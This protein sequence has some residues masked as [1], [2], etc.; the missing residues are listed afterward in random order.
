MSRENERLA[1][2]LNKGLAKLG[3]ALI[4]FLFSSA[5]TK[6]TNTPTGGRV[7]NKVLSKALK[8]ANICLDMFSYGELKDKA[9]LVEA[10]I[11][12][13]WLNRILTLQELEEILVAYLRRLQFNSLELEKELL[14]KGFA[15]VLKTIIE[16]LSVL[17]GQT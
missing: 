7:P 6:A 15:L 17:H 2:E 12:Y 4:N 11:A 3:D 14:A 5:K 13:A 10:I 8:Y 16:R 9:D 1:I